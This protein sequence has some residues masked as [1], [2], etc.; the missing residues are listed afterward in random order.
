MFVKVLIQLKA[1]TVYVI[2]V[3]ASLILGFYVNTKQSTVNMSVYLSLRE[4]LSEAES[5]E[6]W[7]GKCDLDLVYSCMEA[8]HLCLQTQHVLR[9]NTDESNKGK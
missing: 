8:L 2:S 3:F 5:V 7:G 4:L 9:R 6:I 1:C